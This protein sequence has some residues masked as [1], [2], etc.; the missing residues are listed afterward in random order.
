MTA[1]YPVDKVKDN[2]FRLTSLSKLNF[3]LSAGY[4]TTSYSAGVGWPASAE[5]VCFLIS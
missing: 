4:V 1:E 3:L 2:N 5:N